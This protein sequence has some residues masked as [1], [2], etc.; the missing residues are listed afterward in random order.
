MS[1]RDVLG[2]RLHLVFLV[3]SFG[4]PEGMAA[5]NRV[6][7]MGRALIDQNVEVGVLC[8]RVSERP[9]EVRNETASGVAEGI[10]Y[11][12]TT[13][14]TTRSD[15]FVVRRLIEARGYVGAVLELARRRREGRLDCVYLAAL[16]E[17]WTP[18]VWLLLRWLRSCGVPVIIELNEL[19][20]EMTWL[21]ERLSRVVS[22]LDGASGAVAISGW[23]ADWA[24]SEA[25][26]IDKPVRVVEVPIVVDMTEPPGLPYPRGRPRLVY[27]ASDEY[28]RTMT[29]I[30]RALKVVW[31]R[32]PDCELVV[33]GMRPA[34]VTKLLEQE[35]LA[36]ASERIK[37]VGYVDRPRLLRLYG[38][39]TA[40]L[41]PLFDDLRSRARFPTK[42]GEYL[43]SRRPVVTTAVGEI[44]RFFSDGETAFISPPGDPRAFAAK[45]VALLDDPDLARDVGEAGR[46]L[47]DERFEFTR[48]GPPLRAFLDDLCG[49]RA[50][51]GPA[52]DLDREARE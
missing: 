14:S 31:E 2:R 15:R 8:T 36:D 13:G 52:R 29:F 21:P 46:R 32:H 35:G 33:T 5:T 47:A 51:L 23:L 50:G 30:L 28:W 22:H 18:P 41:I 24:R 10:A 3:R 39:A 7:L 12:Y 6:R 27:S 37:A 45:V 44:E 48:Q 40:L 20:S 1:A 42:I 43:A 25:I 49:P 19:P 11:R 34:T 9:G 38:E 26:R 4:F 17:T 16:P